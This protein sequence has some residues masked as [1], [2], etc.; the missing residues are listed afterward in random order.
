MKGQIEFARLELWPQLPMLIE[1][2][3]L[4]PNAF[5][6]LIASYAS[7]IQRAFD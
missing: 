2:S 4:I 5:S 7:F 6:I 3:F 1:A